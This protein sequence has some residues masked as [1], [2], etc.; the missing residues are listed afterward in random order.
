MERKIVE[1]NCEKNYEK[2]NAL[3]KTTPCKNKNPQPKTTTQNQVL[4]E[5]TLSQKQEETRNPLAKKHRA[6]CKNKPQSPAKKNTWKKTHKTPCKLKKRKNIAKTNK[7]KTPCN[8]KTQQPLPKKKTGKKNT[9]TLKQTI[10]KSIEKNT[11]RK[12]V[13]PLAKKKNLPKIT[14]TL[15][16]TLREKNC[17]QK[18]LVEKQKKSL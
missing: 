13:Q 16:K 1:K 11:N 12:N 4:K 7:Q 14:K 2:N 9:K 17:K 3:K 15:A 8:K 5:I 6:T 18:K 10:T